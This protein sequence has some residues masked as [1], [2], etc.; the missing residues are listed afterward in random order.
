MSFTPLFLYEAGM[1]FL[2]YDSETDRYKIAS[3]KSGKE[4]IGHALRDYKQKVPNSPGF[5]SDNGIKD[6]KRTM[7][8]IVITKLRDSLNVAPPSSESNPAVSEAAKA[9]INKTVGNLVVQNPRS[10]RRL[11][12]ILRPLA[13]RP[14]EGSR[15]PP[16]IAFLM[17]AAHQAVEAENRKCSEANSD[18]SAASGVNPPVDMQMPQLPS[19][20]AAAAA[21]LFDGSSTFHKEPREPS[22]AD[23]H[24]IIDA[25]R[26]AV[27]EKPHDDK[28]T[29]LT[30]VGKWL[31]CIEKSH[32]NGRT[33]ALTS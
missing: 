24:A 9:I 31:D 25:L 28:P 26:R 19:I 16:R 7:A 13:P 17:W 22:K 14:L 3:V 21:E 29:T 20:T 8:E 4:K 23:A 5:F 6:W 27:A 33:E 32:R 18:G 30:I 12:P 10:R 15:V 11:Q 2:N 1:R